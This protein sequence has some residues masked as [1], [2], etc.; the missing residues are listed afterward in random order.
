MITVLGAGAWGTALAL[1]LHRNGHR[2]TLW[3]HRPHRADELRAHRENRAYLP[4]VSLPQAIKIEDDLKAA[5]QFAEVLLFAAPSQATGELAVRAA[6]HLG[7]TLRCVLSATKGIERIS[8]SRMSQLLRNA[9]PAQ[10]VGVLS[11]PSHAEEVALTVPAAVTVASEDVATAD[12]LQELFN[13]DRF[14][15]YTSDDVAGVELGGALKNIFAIA[16]GA[17][18]G[19]GLGDNAKAALVT[20]ALTEMTRLGA[21][22]GGRPETFSGLSGV[23]DLVVTCFSRHSRNRAVGERLGEGE[24]PQ[25]IESSMKKVAEGI[26]TSQAAM[27]QVQRLGLE[28][29]VIREVYEMWYHKKA[30]AEALESLMSRAPK[31]ESS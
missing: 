5:V 1:V 4:G 8:G 31:R 25:A 22:L 27:E 23:G 19:L 3:C 15:V 11:G 12:W 21:A 16:A 7:T 30:P 14:R 18:D 13:N 6:E 28:T 26:P 20:R 10:N 24:S 2:V 17:S 9:F 29:P